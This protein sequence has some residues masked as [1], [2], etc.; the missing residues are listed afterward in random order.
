MLR[1]VAIAIE[2]FESP[3]SAPMQDCLGA[4]DSIQTEA[5]RVIA[6]LSA[7]LPSFPDQSPQSLNGDGD[8]RKKPNIRFGTA[9]KTVLMNGKRLQELRTQIRGVS[10]SLSAALIAAN[11]IQINEMRK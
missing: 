10:T 5:V 3:L 4:I 6:R 8:G 2:S 11:S 9:L 7:T 1:A